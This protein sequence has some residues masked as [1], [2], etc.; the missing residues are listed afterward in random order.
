MPVPRWYFE[1]YPSKVHLSENAN[2]SYDRPLLTGDF[3]SSCI[4]MNVDKKYKLFFLTDLLIPKPV[5]TCQ[6]LLSK[7]KSNRYE[8]L[9]IHVVFLC[10]VF[11]L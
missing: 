9:H 7:E 8:V 10:I 3:R 6:K 1:P 5:K 4:C 11:I 2:K